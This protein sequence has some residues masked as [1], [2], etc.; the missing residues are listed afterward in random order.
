[1]AL[2]QVVPAPGARPAS[3]G[4]LGTTA[5][6]VSLGKGEQIAD[7]LSLDVLQAGETYQMLAQ[8]GVH[9]RSLLE[10]TRARTPQDLLVDGNRQVRHGTVLV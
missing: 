6:T 10:R 3:F 4:S 7:C 8:D 9:A 1:M 5:A 2:M